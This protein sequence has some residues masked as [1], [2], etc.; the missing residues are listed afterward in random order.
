MVPRES[1][2]LH[3]QVDVNRHGGRRDA[4]LLFWSPNLLCGDA[5]EIYHVKDWF[6]VQ[7]GC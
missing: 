4:L 5:S 7:T 6:H 2:I 1:W 3:K